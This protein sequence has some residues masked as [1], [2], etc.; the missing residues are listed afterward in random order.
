MKKSVN[1]FL[2]TIVAISS[3]NNINQAISIIRISGKDSTK[4]IKKYLME[5][6][7]PIKQLHM[8]ILLILTQK[9]LLMKFWLLGL[10]E[11]IITQVKIQ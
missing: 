10:L 8:D 7:E 4:I 1:K 3:G 9:N 5:K 2:D 6:L 11:L